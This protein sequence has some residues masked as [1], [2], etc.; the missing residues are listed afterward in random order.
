VKYSILIYQP[1][2]YFDTQPDREAELW[3]A[4]RAYHQALTDAGVYLGSTALEQPATAT[5]L[6]VRAERRLVQDGPFAETKE[7][8][9]GFILLE[10]PSLKEALEW[11]AR[12]PGAK[13]GAVEVRPIVSGAHPFADQGYE[14]AITRRP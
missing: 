11:A 3:G 10:T 4:W 8:L 13:Y 2:T 7:Q 9:A 14:A 5:T 12:C 1:D 6:R